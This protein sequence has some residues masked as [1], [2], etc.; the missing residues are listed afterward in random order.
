MAIG[1]G[2]LIA[3][4]VAETSTLFGFSEG[5]LETVMWVAIVSEAAAVILLAPVGVASLVGSSTTRAPSGQ[6]AA[7]S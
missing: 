7:R 5:T 2:S 3:L 4:Y 1:L 6:R